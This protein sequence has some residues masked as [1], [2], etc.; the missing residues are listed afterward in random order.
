MDE[1]KT[2]R[3]FL[4]AGK[5]HEAGSILNRLIQKNRDSDELWY[6]LG[7]LA[8]KL[9]NY[10]A[11]HEYL[12]RALSLEK[13]P[14]Y[15]WFKGMA[16]MET[17]EIADAIEVFEEVLRM[18][19]NN[20]DANFFLSVCCLLLDDS[21]SEIY[22]KKAYK[23]DKKKTKQLMKNFFEAFISRTPGLRPALKSKIE[24]ELSSL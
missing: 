1:L 8:V 9:K 24:K 4:A 20:V 18:D 22:M 2:A 23:L 10:D 17:L 16:Y 12:E 21:R 19:K 6:F 14:E 7:V 5:Y 15:L 13:K 3:D 11:A